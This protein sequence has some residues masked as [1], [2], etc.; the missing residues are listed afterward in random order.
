MADGGTVSVRFTVAN[1]EVVRQAL[2]QLGK[3]GATALKQF[4][5]SAQ[6]SAQSGGKLADVVQAVRS[7]VE[8][9]A[10]RGGAV[11][12]IISGWGPAGLGAAAG[13]GGVYLAI[14]RINEIAE[15]FSAKAQK[16]RDSAAALGLTTTTI[17]ALNEA[18]GR[19]SLTGDQ[20]AQ[21]LARFGQASDEARRAQ[22]DLYTTIR[23]VD[24]ALAEQLLTTRDQAAALDIL[25]RA[26]Q[27]A[28]QAQRLTLSKVLGKDAGFG[29]LLAEINRAGGVRS[30]TAAQADEAI[31]QQVIERVTK[32]RIEIANIR[33]RTSNIWG[34]IF[35][36]DVLESQKRSAEFWERVAKAAERFLAA[37]N[38]ATL[39]D[40]PGTMD[41]ALPPGYQPGEPGARVTVTPPPRGYRVNAGDQA[42]RDT[43]APERVTAEARLNLLRQEIA[44][45]G[46]AVTPAELLKLKTLELAAAN[47]KGGV[48]VSTHNRALDAF[49][50]AQAQTAASIRERVGV[51]TEQE[52]I[53]VRLAELQDLRAKGFIRNAEQMAQA[54]KLVRKE[55]GDTMNALE[56]R[57]SATPALTQLTQDAGD[58]SK[59]LDN[60][61]AGAVRSL[62]SEFS[63]LN[64][65][66]DSAGKRLAN[67]ALRFADAALQAI[68]MKHAIAPLAQYGGSFL[69]GM[70][71]GGGQGG[72]DAA[73]DAATRSANGNA[74]DRAGLI[75]F[76]RGG[77]VNRPTIFPFAR[78]MGLM[79]EA[80]P[81]AIMPLK[82]G[83]DGRLGVTAMNGA[84]GVSVTVNNYTP[85]RVE[86]RQRRSATGEIDLE[87]SVIEA[88]ANDM[89]RGG[90]TA[91]AA[92]QRFGLDPTR[93]MAG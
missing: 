83:A 75:P 92:Q 39:A 87:F 56:V 4:D 70:F 81:E 25:A 20:V 74:F 33:E 91:A 14:D 84:A 28:D 62:S 2:A 85:A 46:Q 41:F 57:R 63:L 32:L 82:R 73:V 17:Q 79:G 29:N 45:L 54:E 10:A 78:G 34:Q 61:L 15:D 53:E 6:A 49:K 9:L 11:S 22:G 5:A 18:G 60:N 30:L 36:P 44:L 35:S 89:A 21:G 3:D 69:S 66:T 64:Q 23:R 77:V 12:G 7:R 86:T 93:G 24:P 38:G 55:V 88:V 48:S 19:V 52:L 43:P 80:G 40:A 50:L 37:R 47:E 13:L 16:I 65:T 72:W 26:Y 27:R 8:G 71:G 58:L 31:P 42:L 90:R 59:Q 68:I 1:A 51:V 67:L 76:A